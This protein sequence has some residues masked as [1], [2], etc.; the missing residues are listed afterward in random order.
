MRKS[1]LAALCVASCGFAAQADIVDVID[2]ELCQTAADMEGIE[3]K[4]NEE[5]GE[6]GATMQLPIDGALTDS[7]VSYR[8]GFVQSKGGDS[9]YFLYSGY[10][11]ST[12]NPS[13]LYLKEMRINYAEGN[14]N[15]AT[16]YFR[17]DPVGYHGDDDAYPNVGYNYDTW[18]QYPGNDQVWPEYDGSSTFARPEGAYTNFVLQPT[19][20][21]ITNIELTWSE[22]APV[23]QVKTP[24]IS[25]SQQLYGFT[26]TGTPVK[27]TCDTNSDTRQVTYHYSVTDENGATTQSGEGTTE[28]YWDAY[29]FNIEGEAGQHLTVNAYCT[30][31]GWE[32]SD[33]ATLD[34]EI[35]LPGLRSLDNNLNWGYRPIFGSS[36][37]V[38]NINEVGDIHYIVN[39]GEEQV[40]TEKTLTLPLVGNIGDNYTFEGWVAAEG[41]ANSETTVFEAT[42]QSNALKAPY[43]TPAGGEVRNGGLV[44]ITCEDAHLSG[45]FRYRVNNG[46]WIESTEPFDT[47]VTITEDCT[48]EAQTIPQPAGGEYDFMVA[49]DFSSASFT[50]EVL[51]ENDIEILPEFF[52]P[53]LYMSWGQADVEINGVNFHYFGNIESSWSTGVGYFQFNNMYFALANTTAFPGGINSFKLDYNNEWN[54]GTVVYFAD[55]DISNVSTE[56]FTAEY[57][58]Q[59]TMDN[60]IWMNSNEGSQWINL[61]GTANAGKPYMLI[62]NQGMYESPQLI[63]VVLS[64]AANTGVAAVSDA[65]VSDAVYTVSGT[66][67]AA[68]TLTPG[69]YI[70]VKEGKASKILVK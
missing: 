15:Y 58:G 16:F 31:E 7:G 62:A 28:N 56:G 4:T 20:Y 40:C 47:N 49:S 65:A 25:L 66:R 54:N 8:V 17:N 36:F 21:T 35:T 41:Y 68:E 44:S 13:G 34:V 64:G 69:L 3:L 10:V 23:P 1:L 51:G 67:V 43:F 52:S 48:I 59:E 50:V 55:H 57:L 11:A 61:E 5:W 29:T 22:T 14:S 32:Q 37:T 60:A 19:S 70:V 30:L 46:E 27:I 6:Y 9:L 24:R 12:E 26:P 2:F 53:D 39:G 42:V 45:G 38:N 63:R 33:T 18:S